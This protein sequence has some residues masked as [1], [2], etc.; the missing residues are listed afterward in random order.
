LQF[1]IP[2]VSAPLREKTPPKEDPAMNLYEIIT[3]SDKITFETDNEQALQ[4]GFLM[5]CQSGMI[6]LKRL[7][8]GEHVRPLFADEVWASEAIPTDLNQY[9]DE[10]A[11]TVADAL[12]SILYG[13]ASDRRLF[14]EATKTMSPEEKRQFREKW[15]EEKRTSMTDY[16][17]PALRYA[18]K[19]RRNHPEPV[20]P[21]QPTIFVIP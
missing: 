20:P 9:L 21:V 8:D 19:L 6:G 3:P 4:V 5:I 16:G 15:N 13:D 17:T 10:N 2:S 12:E 7:E 11:W 1:A 14:D 18:D